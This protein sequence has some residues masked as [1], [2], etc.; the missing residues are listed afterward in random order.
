MNIKVLHINTSG[1]GGAAIACHRLHDLMLNAGIQSEVLHM[2]EN[3]PVNEHYHVLGYKT[4]RKVLN[5]AVYAITQKDLTS[6][7]Y[8]FNEMAPIRSGVAS[9][10]LVQ[11]SDVIYLHWVLGGLMSKGDFEDLARTG[12]PIFCFTHDMWWITG[13][14]HYSFD[15]EGY[16]SGCKKCPKH[17]HFSILTSRQSAWKKKFYGGYPNVQFIAPSDWLRKCADRSSAMN[18]KRCTFI[19]N[20]VPDRIF[21]YIDKAQAKERFGLPKDKVI[22]SFGTADNSNVVKGMKYLVDALKTISD[23][24]LLLCVYGSERDENLEREV[25]QPIRFLGRF[26]DPKDVAMANAAADVFVSPTLAESFGQ[27][28]LENIKCGTPVISTR[29]TAVPEIV[30][31]GI[32]GYLVAPKDSK[33]LASAIMKF[34]SNPIRIDGSYNKIFSEESVLSKHLALIRKSLNG[35]HQ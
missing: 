7:A 25:L 23:D 21:R 13:G 11:Q 35:K 29:T 18:Q 28:L 34:V 15:C 26:T 3:C 33:G 4:M 5:H 19:P 17:K 30:Q 16:K 14:C 9:H 24:R 12:K 20:I 8:V 27:T 32:N 2:Y 6:D 1:V 31:D 10:P 22:I